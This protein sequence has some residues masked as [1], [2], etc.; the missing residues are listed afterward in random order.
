MN[1]T[2]ICS[3][4]KAG[5]SR[6]QLEGPPHAWFAELGVQHPGEEGCGWWPVG[7][8]TERPEIGSLRQAEA[9]GKGAAVEKQTKEAHDIVWTDFEKGK[10]GAK[11]A[12]RKA[13]GGPSWV[14]YA[15]YLYR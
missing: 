2:S 9:Q 13:G 8:R 1:G 12:L 11:P 6:R 10:R 4:I 3:E 14:C 5:A 15:F 7:I